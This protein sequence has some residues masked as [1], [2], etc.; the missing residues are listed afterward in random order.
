[1]IIIAANLRR[2]IRFIARSGCAYAQ[3]LRN[4]S[5]GFGIRDALCAGES[6]NTELTTKAD[7]TQVKWN[8]P[9]AHCISSAALLGE[10]R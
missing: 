7:E 5:Q 8:E 1:M 4:R 9:H 2:R 6:C 3:I 10:T